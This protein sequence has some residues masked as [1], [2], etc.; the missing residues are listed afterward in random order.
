MSTRRLVL[1]AVLVTV[2]LAVVGS[3]VASRDPDGLTKVAEEQG[4]AH[5]GAT[6]HGLL[7]YGPVAGVVGMLLVLAL[8]VG[9]VRLA[10]RR[11]HED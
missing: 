5:T 1:G 7:S 3:L 11:G 2:L 8:A 10:R 9:L 4:F 6:S